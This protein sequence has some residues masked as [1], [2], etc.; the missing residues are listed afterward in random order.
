MATIHTLVAGDWIDGLARRYGIGSAAE[1]WD[2]ARNVELR[3][4]RGTPDLLMVGDR[5]FIPDATRSRCRLATGRRHVVQVSPP[6]AVLRLRLPD[7]GPMIDAFG[8]MAYELRAG[9]HTIRGTLTSAGDVVE[10]PL[11]PSTRHAELKLRGVVVQRFDIGGLGPVSEPRGALAR[12]QNLG[13]LGDM[14]ERAGEGVADPLVCALQRFQRSHGL[15]VTG[16]LDDVTKAALVA[17]Y[18]A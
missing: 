5:I 4:L 11:S 18:G 17:T 7:L 8:P 6:R 12:L 16:V 3:A 1:I 15:P 2:H 9:D 10:V 13:L 14:P